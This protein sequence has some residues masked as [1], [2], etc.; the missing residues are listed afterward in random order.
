MAKKTRGRGR[1]RCQCQSMK[2]GSGCTT[3]N[4]QTGGKMLGLNPVSLTGDSFDRSGSSLA[5]Q[6]HNLYVKQSHDLSSLK[7]GRARSK[8]RSAKKY[9]RKSR[10]KSRSRSRSRSKH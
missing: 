10:S 8:G 5:K 4:M 6:A 9:S 7:G 3:C 1:T 2:G